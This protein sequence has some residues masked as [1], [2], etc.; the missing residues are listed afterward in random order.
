MKKKRIVAAG[1][2]VQKNTVLQRVIAD[3]FGSEPVITRRTDEAATGAALFSAVATGVIPNIEAIAEYI[4]YK[5]KNN[6]EC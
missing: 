1:G 6:N 3:M 2:A 5:E 4:T